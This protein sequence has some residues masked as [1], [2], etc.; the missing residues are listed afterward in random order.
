MTGSTWKEYVL[1]IKIRFLSHV[2]IHSQVIPCVHWGRM[3]HDTPIKGQISFHQLMASTEQ[4][5]VEH[6]MSKKLI[7]I[8]IRENMTSHEPYSISAKTAASTNQ[9]P[10]VQVKP[11][12]QCRQRGS[13]YLQP[14]HRIRSTRKEYD[15]KI[16]AMPWL[17]VYIDIAAIPCAQRQQIDQDTHVW[18]Q[19]WHDQINA[20]KNFLL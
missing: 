12:I 19:G 2:Y 15:W 11:D 20:S 18:L 13:N 3:N 16:N 8:R 10:H 1:I 7:G 9:R 17:Y 14:I 6:L 5:P 4:P